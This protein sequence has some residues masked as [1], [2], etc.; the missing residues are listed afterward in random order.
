[1]V[2]APLLWG[3]FFQGY[4]F[5]KWVWPCII[6]GARPPTLCYGPV[7]SIYRGSRLTLLIMEWNHLIVTRAHAIVKVT[8]AAFSASKSSPSLV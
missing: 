8:Y 5:P 6:L 2:L 3:G 1:M 7:V 4:G